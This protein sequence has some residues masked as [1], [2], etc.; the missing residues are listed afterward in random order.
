V[1]AALLSAIAVGLG[2]VLDAL[3][4]H[5]TFVTVRVGTAFLGSSAL[6]FLLLLVVLC[7]RQRRRRTAAR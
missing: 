6:A 3:F 1:C 2:L 4:G 7:A 5:R